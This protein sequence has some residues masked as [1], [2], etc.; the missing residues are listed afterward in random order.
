VGGAAEIEALRGPETEVIDGRGATL[1]SGFVESH[2]H[3]FM[4][5]LS[6]SIFSS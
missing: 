6:L 2:C 1:L 3:V 4:G 5:A